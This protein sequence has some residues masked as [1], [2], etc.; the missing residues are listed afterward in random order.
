MPTS[1][2]ATAAAYTMTAVPASASTAPS[3]PRCAPLP[4][5][6]LDVLAMFMSLNH[7]LSNRGGYL[8]R[9]CGVRRWSL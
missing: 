9:S 7:N 8:M 1:K 5:R 6:L 4:H 3:L 2:A